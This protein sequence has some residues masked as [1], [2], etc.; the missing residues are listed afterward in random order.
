MAKPT[1]WPLVDSVVI[2]YDSIK[3]L[4]TKRKQMSRE[5]QIKKLENEL[6]Y[7]N[8]SFAL[9][10][11]FAMK[12]LLYFKG[13]AALKGVISF[14]AAALSVVLLLLEKKRKIRQLNQFKTA[15]D[16]TIGEVK[17]VPHIGKASKVSTMPLKRR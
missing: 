9:A 7:I 2:I 4:F 15:S 6:S 17:K 3:S 16:Y 5:E 14:A 1:G 10:A 11:L 13:G 8:A 12:G